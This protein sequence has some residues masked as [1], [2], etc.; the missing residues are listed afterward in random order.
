MLDEDKPD[1]IGHLDKIKMFNKKGRFFDESEKWYTEQVDMTIDTL[2]KNSTIVEVNTRG[3]YRY[4][5]TELYPGDQI[6]EKLNK[7]KVPIM[8]NSDSHKPEE[9]IMGMPYAAEKLMSLG[10]KRIFA[11]H[12]GKWQ[13]FSFDRNGIFWSPNDFKK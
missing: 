10:V 4:Q 6:I 12:S 2:K 7:A 8:I 5:Q 3:F 13:E 9:I 11:L 1:I